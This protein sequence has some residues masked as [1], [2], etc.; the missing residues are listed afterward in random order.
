MLS[1]EKALSSRVSVHHVDLL[2]TIKNIDAEDHILQ[3][4]KI[5]GPVSQAAM[6]PG[7]PTT[8]VDGGEVS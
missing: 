1:L 7:S 2:P 6:Q 4:D 3:R 8:N 5:P